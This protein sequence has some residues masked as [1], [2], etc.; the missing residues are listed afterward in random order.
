VA[1]EA[2]GASAPRQLEWQAPDG[3]LLIADAYGDPG[4]PPALFLHGG[5][6]T[7]HAWGGTARILAARG[8]HAISLD[9]RGHGD[10]SWSRDGDYR[11]ERFVADLELVADTLHAP[12]VLIGASL[13][14]MTSLVA[15]GERPG[16]ARAVVLVDVAHR[17]ELAG[18][19]RI[20]EFMTDRLHEGFGDL[21]EAADAVAA[22]M[23]HRRRPKDLTGLRK[24]LREG[25]DGRFRWHWDPKFMLGERGPGVLDDPNRLANAAR[26][27]AVPTLVV[28][29]RMSDVLSEEVARE[30]LDL[31]PHARA[32]DVSEAGH[33]VAGD[34]NDLFTQAVVDF[35]DEAS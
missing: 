9:L 11:I 8:W 31:A 21:E 5:G 4:H 26:A 24:N 13:G 2:R 25:P 6:Q 1:P 17:V 20:F 19:E 28:R 35:L 7:R 14:G 16:F 15:V 27:L 22:Y 23:P 30:F 32:V 34:R 12:P 29:G 18:V 3:A 10:S 33:M